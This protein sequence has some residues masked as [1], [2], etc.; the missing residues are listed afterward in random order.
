MNSALHS[1]ISPTDTGN[2]VNVGAMME[3]PTASA[4]GD[5]VD[6]QVLINLHA[7]SVPAD[8]QAHSEALDGAGFFQG[9][10]LNVGTTRVTALDAIPKPTEAENESLLNMPPAVVEDEKFDDVSD[11]G[12]VSIATPREPAADEIQDPSAEQVASLSN[13]STE[14]ADLTSPQ[15][16]SVHVNNDWLSS[17]CNVCNA[18]GHL[19]DDC[20]QSYHFYL[21]DET[22]NSGTIPKVPLANFPIE[23]SC[24]RCASTQHLG[25]D[26][27]MDPNPVKGVHSAAFYNHFLTKPLP[28]PILDSHVLTERDVTDGAPTKAPRVIKRPNRPP[29]KRLAQHRNRGPVPNNPP[30]KRLAQRQNQQN[31]APVML[32]NHRVE[33]RNSWAPPPSVAPFYRPNET[34][35]RH[36]GPSYR[37][38]LR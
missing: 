36:G 20:P 14:S 25:D 24:Y 29:S 4:P 19:V 26:C 15:L 16:M 38:G 35:G 33:Y 23:I 3:T 6:E 18:R 8:D 37:P 31:Q 1:T 2:E 7:T 9:Q 27:P 5:G 11:N 12:S 30:S 28:E 22:L 10:L 13:L 32:G 21:K 34:A 17:H